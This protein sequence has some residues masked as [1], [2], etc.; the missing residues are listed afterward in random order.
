MMHCWRCGAA[1]SSLSPDVSTIDVD[2]V[3]AVLA[4]P[5]RRSLLDQLAKDGPL[6]ATQLAQ[7]YTVT[8]QAVVKHLAVMADAGLLQSERQ[9]REVRYELR[10]AQ[11]DEAAAWLSAVGAQWDRRLHALERH[12]ARRQH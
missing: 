3:F 1:T 2:A 12:F 7:T 4:D 8:R 11:L 10:A 6:S 5:T 9:G